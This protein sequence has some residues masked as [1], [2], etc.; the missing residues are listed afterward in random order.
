M[1]SSLCAPAMDLS[2]VRSGFHPT[3]A[4]IHLQFTIKSFGKI[5][6][7]ASWENVS[8]YNNI[9]FRFFFF[10]KVFAKNEKNAC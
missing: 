3:P 7:L 6:M 2:G 4:P 10:F 1:S 8:C 5:S 9:T